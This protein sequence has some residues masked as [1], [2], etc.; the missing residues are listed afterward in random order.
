METNDE[1]LTLA[2]AFSK[3]VLLTEINLLYC[4]HS[5]TWPGYLFS[6]PYARLFPHPLASPPLFFP[7]PPPLFWKSRPF[8]PACLLDIYPLFN[9]SEGSVGRDPALQCEQ[10]F[11]HS[12]VSSFLF[13]LRMPHR[14]SKISRWML[15]VLFLGAC[16]LMLAYSHIVTLV[17]G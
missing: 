6:V 11:Y 15:P 5:V 12:T 9:Q 7:E 14:R 2:L 10:I 17:E 8:S 16:I 3:L 1:G 13:L 4:L